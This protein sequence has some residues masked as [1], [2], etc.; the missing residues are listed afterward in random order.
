MDD[1][2]LAHKQLAFMFRS[3]YK[4]KVTAPSAADTSFRR[5]PASWRM[6]CIESL[7]LSTFG[8]RYNCLP[9]MPLKDEEQEG[10]TYNWQAC[11]EIVVE[12]QSRDLELT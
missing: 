8:K 4:T 6:R 1:S 10:L 12:N 11:A 5:L 2:N 9:H 3:N 7:D